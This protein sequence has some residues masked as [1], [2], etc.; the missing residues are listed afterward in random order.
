MAVLVV[1]LMVVAALVGRIPSASKES[2]VVMVVV[3]VLLRLMMR[4][5]GMT[6]TRELLIEVGVMSE[7][8]YLLYLVLNASRLSL[9]RPVCHK[10]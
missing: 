8:L 1:V 2:V 4:C 7:L 10:L 6:M 3:V 9:V 5:I